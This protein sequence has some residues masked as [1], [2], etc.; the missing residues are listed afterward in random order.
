MKSVLYLGEWR[1]EQGRKEIV[2]EAGQASCSAVRT[3]IKVI[4]IYQVSEYAERLLSLLY[5]YN[6]FHLEKCG[7]LVLLP[8]AIVGDHL[9][10]LKVR[11]SQLTL[12]NLSR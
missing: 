1:Q 12:L 2:S 7:Q 4:V 3:K 8:A 10:V 11:Q 6:N 9:Q 5:M